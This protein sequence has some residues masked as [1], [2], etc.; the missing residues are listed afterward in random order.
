MKNFEKNLDNL[1]QGVRI[2]LARNRS[3]LS[4]DD[5]A[6]LENVV[7]SLEELKEVKSTSDRKTFLAKLLPA[8]IK[9]FFRF[10]LY[11]ELSEVFEDLLNF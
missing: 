2:V 10:K 3:S 5:V 7:S 6:R 8:L 9:T 11:E 4:I 1:A